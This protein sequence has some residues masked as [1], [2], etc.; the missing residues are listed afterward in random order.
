MLTCTQVPL[1]WDIPLNAVITTTFIASAFS[2]INIGST[3]AFNQI[4]SLGLCALLS[5]YLV[6]ISCI[7]LKRMRKEPLL[8]AYFTLG[9]YGLAINIVSILFLLLAYIMIFFPPT[10]N[11]IVSGMNWSVVIYVGVMS[12][13]LIYFYFKGRYVY[14]GPVEYVKK[15]I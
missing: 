1:G 6:S 7:A 5:S 8:N 2:L 11:P 4:T 10:P 9:K 12:I 15:D 13:S 3:I 14:V